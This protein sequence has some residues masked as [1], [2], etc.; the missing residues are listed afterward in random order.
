[1][2]L[3]RVCPDVDEDVIYI[4]QILIDGAWEVAYFE[5]DGVDDTLDFN[6]YVLDF[7]ASRR[8]H[9]QGNG[10]G[11]GGS[12]ITYRNDDGHLKLGL[13]FGDHD[14]FY[15]LNNRWKIIVVNENRIELVD[16]SSNGEIEK[17][18]VL[19]RY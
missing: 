13:N 9:V 6:D 19:E 3:K 2:V 11:F 10:Q 14:I 12:W 5:E 4:N 16:F 1:M 8:V 18:L 17:K 15:E 7:L